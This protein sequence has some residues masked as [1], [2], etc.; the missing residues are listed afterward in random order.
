MIAGAVGVVVLIAA[1]VF[2]VMP[3]LS[4]PGG[5]HAASGSLFPTTSPSAT[6]TSSGTTAKSSSTG[7]GATPG[8]TQT[9]PSTYTLFFQV[10]KDVISGDVTVTVTG[11][12]RNVVKDIEVRLTRADGQ[13]IT[14]DIIP[15]QKINDVTLPGTRNSERVEVTV[16]FYSGEQYKVLDTIAQFNK[17]M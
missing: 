14:K 10:D 13:V 3:M 16:Q 7:S 2:V 15:S 1:I 8:P 9:L 11:P 12:S 5:T 4:G 17:R 6:G